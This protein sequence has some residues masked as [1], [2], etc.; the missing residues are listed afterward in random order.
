M[1]LEI[2]LWYTGKKLCYKKGSEFVLR[3]YCDSDYAADVDG[4]RSISGVVFTLGGNTISWKSSLQDVVALSTTEAEYMVLNETVKE[5]LW[6]KGILKEFGYEQI[7]VDVF[8]D[9]QSAIGYQRTTF[10][11]NEPNI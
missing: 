1:G 6:L 2:H 11:M 3:G 9:S 8:C 4:R 5:A 7:A 10:I